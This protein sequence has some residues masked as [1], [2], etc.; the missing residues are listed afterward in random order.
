MAA[1][2]RE[3]ESDLRVAT[4]GTVPE[5]IFHLEA[6]AIRE[7][8]KPVA[9]ALSDAQ[10]D[11]SSETAEA[12]PGCPVCD[13][14]DLQNREDIDVAFVCGKASSRIDLAV[15]MLRAG[16]HSVVQP[17]SDFSSDEIARLRTEA[18][19]AGR[20]AFVWRPFEAEPDFRQAEQVVTSGEAGSVHTARFIEHDLAA[21]LLPDASGPGLRERL[22]EHSLLDLVGHRLA[23]LLTFISQPVTSL[24]ALSSTHPITFGSSDETRE[25]TPEFTTAINLQIEFEGGATAILDLGRSCPVSVDTG[26]ILQCHQGG[27]HN[28]RQH[29]TVEDGELYDVAVEVEPHDSYAWLRQVIAAWPDEASVQAVSQKLNRE[30][31]V[32]ELIHRA[33]A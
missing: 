2:H 28:G 4:A 27:Y 31:Q 3:S 32:A 26:W 13:L 7:G 29:I 20:A 5:A 16:K 8:L 23:Q 9:A 1:E 24:S 12:I 15:R 11:C 30:L 22:T 14:D 17:S 33:F 25:V 18:E 10:S 21:A 19:A 6:C